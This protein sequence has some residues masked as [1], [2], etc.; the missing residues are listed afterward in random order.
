MRNV[1]GC[2]TGTSIDGLD[3]ALVAIEGHGLTMRAM[4]LRSASHSLGELQQPLRRLADQHAMTAGEIARLSLQYSR[5]HAAAILEL[6]GSDRLDFVCIHGQTVFHDPPCSWQMLTPAVI[7]AQIDAPVVF[8]LRAADLAAG[9]Q[10][11]P[12]T[13]IADFVLF[14]HHAEKRVVL[15]LGGFCNFTRLPPVAESA[16]QNTLAIASDQIEGGDICTCNHLLNGIA[17]AAIGRDFDQD[18]AVAASGTVDE[19][20]AA[21]LAALVDKQ[22]RAGRSLGTGDELAHWIVAAAKRAAPATVLRSACVAIA[23]TIASRLRKVDRIIVGGGSVA[24]RAL[25]GAIADACAAPVQS[26][27]DF[28]IPPSDREAVCMA[29]LGALCADGVPITLPRVTGA[30]RPTPVSGAW[31]MPQGSRSM[32]GS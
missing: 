10:G 15:N 22:A 5:L 4:P 25:L 26:S 30:S 19:A 16:D 31:A 6:R 17:R 32:L 12:I 13:P 3:A 18:G 11:A 2:M 27:A 1:I 29:I 8:D 28:G 20:I 7:A 14:R 21:E 24:N 23:R 9:G